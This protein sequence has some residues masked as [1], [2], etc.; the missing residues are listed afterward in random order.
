MRDRIQPNAPA[1]VSHASTH[2]IHAHPL[3]GPRHPTAQRLIEATLASI[4]KNGGYRGVNI[5][6]IA[7]EAKCVHTNIYKHF[8]SLECLLWAAVD[9]ALA[10]QSEYLEQRMNSSAGQE[11]PLKTFLEA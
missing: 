6:L 8:K 5:R 3:Q 7:A 9:Q 11:F 2:P 4:A 1:R 10:R